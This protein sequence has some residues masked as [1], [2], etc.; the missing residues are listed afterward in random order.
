M[1]R[2]AIAFVAVGALLAGPVAQ[3]RTKLT[4]DQQLA[5][6][7]KGRVAGK[8]VSCI[9]LNQ[10]DNTTIIDKT[11]IVYRDGGTLYVNRPNNADSLDSDDLLVTKTFSS[12]L[13]RLDMVQLHQRSMP[14]MWTGFVSLQ[15]FVPYRKPPK[16]ARP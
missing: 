4:P 5:K 7:L 9:Q 10:V 8:P 2:I 14:S 6:M 15:D 13:C 16:T 12:S 1:K 3:A 11:A